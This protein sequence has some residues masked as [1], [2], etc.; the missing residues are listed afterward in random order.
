MGDMPTGDEE[1]RVYRKGR[2]FRGF[3]VEGNGAD[4][5]TIIKEREEIGLIIRKNSF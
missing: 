1:W 5:I 3:G 4:V 2:W